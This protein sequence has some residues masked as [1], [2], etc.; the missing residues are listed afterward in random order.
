LLGCQTLIVTNA[1]GALSADV[2]P[3]DLMAISDHINFQNQ[4]PLVGRNDPAFGPRFP[5]MDNAYDAQLRALLQEH[6][7]SLGIPLREGVYLGVLG[8]SFETPAEIRA[9]A[10][11]GANA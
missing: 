11:L 4:N 3:G 9:F 5:P 8:P 6:A 7:A 1:A 10:A 2:Q